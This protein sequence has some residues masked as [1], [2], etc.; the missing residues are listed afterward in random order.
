MN[1]EN[2]VSWF[3][4]YVDDIERAKN[5]YESVLET[6]MSELPN[7]TGDG[8]QMMAFPMTMEKTN[9]AAGA[10]VKMEGMSAGG[11]STIIYFE[12]ENCSVEQARVEDAGGK[13]F[14]TK[15]DLGNYGFMVLAT[16]PEGNMVGI[17][18]MK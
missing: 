6:Q 8:A 10:L 4:I 5:F 16:D 1:R 14:K 9:G 7:P 3:E 17:H 18:S 11:N 13:V 15:T 2:P 12:S